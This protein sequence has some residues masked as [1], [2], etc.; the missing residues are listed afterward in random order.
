VVAYNSL[1]EAHRL[2]EEQSRLAS[3]LKYLD[4]GGKVASV[5]IMPLPQAPGEFPTMGGMSVG[6]DTTD[7]SDELVQAVRAVVVAKHDAVCGQLRELGVT[8][9]PERKEAN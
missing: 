6:V 2:Y 3:A 7:A 9:T 4:S 1:A 8:D 5:M